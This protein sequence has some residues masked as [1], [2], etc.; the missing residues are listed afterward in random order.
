MQ[1]LRIVSSKHKCYHMYVMVSKT[2]KTRTYSR[3]RSKASPM[4]TRKG[5]ERFYEPESFFF[6]KLVIIIVLSASWLRFNNPLEVG[7]FSIAAFPLGLI[8]ALLFILWIEKYQFNRKIWY[9]VTI[10][11]AIVS[12]FTPV[13][14]IV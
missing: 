1:V 14:I 6:L 5:K 3:N 4:F 12:S 9:S 11:M 10:L 2:Q 13:G 7:S 8:V